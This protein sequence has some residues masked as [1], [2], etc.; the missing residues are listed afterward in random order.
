MHTKLLSP[1][2]NAMHS[3]NKRRRSLQPTGS[4]I[5]ARTVQKATLLPLGHRCAE[6]FT[7][8]AVQQLCRTHSWSLSATTARGQT[9]PTSCLPRK[10]QKNRHGNTQAGS[11][12][13]LRCW[14]WQV[15]ASYKVQTLAW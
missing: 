2:H 4:A 15:V 9:L 11:E 7:S 3:R 12:I 10:G 14:R 1:Q 6:S 5:G 8:E 13:L